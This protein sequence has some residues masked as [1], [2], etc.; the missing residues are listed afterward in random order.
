MTNVTHN[1]LVN[2]FMNQKRREDPAK[3][4][5]IEKK[6]PVLSFED[7]KKVS[8]TEVT[9]GLVGLQPSRLSTST[10]EDND[11]ESVYTKN[12]GDV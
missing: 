5:E 8:K 1:Q 7:W 4:R 11:T 10:A 2:D 9:S 12:E 6:Y 3:V